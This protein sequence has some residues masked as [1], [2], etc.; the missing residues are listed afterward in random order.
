ML[1]SVLSHQLQSAYAIHVRTHQLVF[2]GQVLRLSYDELG[3][4]YALYEPT[5]ARDAQ[6]ARVYLLPGK[7][8]KTLGSQLI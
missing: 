8:T 2:P 4:M 7:G 6:A 5:H 3:K 1:Y